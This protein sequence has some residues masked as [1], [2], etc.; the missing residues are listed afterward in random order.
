MS[1]TQPLTKELMS[2]GL[3]KNNNP[4]SVQLNSAKNYNQKGNNIN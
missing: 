2:L 1:N 3:N 4:Q